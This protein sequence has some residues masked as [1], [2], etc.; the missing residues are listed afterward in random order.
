VRKRWDSCKDMRPATAEECKLLRAD[1]ANPP[2]IGH[3]KG[4][5]N[6]RKSGYKGRIAASEILPFNDEVDELVLND[7]PLSQ[8][9]KAAEKSGFVPMVEDAVTKVLEG[10]TSLE[11]AIKVVDFTDRF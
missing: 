6:C 7:A 2:T 3:P 4:C 10:R 1:P 9:K 5:D 11:A 8:I